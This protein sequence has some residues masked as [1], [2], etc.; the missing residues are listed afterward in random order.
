MAQ[1]IDVV[2][3]ATACKMLN[4]SRTSF[5]SKYK[6]KLNPLPTTTNRVLYKKDDVDE[7]VKESAEIENQ[8][9]IIT[10]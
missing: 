6:Q 7:L 4:C 9:N 2:T 10:Q 1:K 3:I 5:Y 8:Y